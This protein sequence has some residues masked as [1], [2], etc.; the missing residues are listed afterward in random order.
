MSE[1]GWSSFKTD[2]NSSEGRNV[3]APVVPESKTNMRFRDGSDSIGNGLPHTGFDAVEKLDAYAN[4]LLKKCDQLL[5]GF[6]QP[7]DRPRSM[8]SSLASMPANENC[9]NSGS[10]G[11]D[12]AYDEANDEDDND[13]D[14]SVTAVGSTATI[15]MGTSSGVQMAADSFSHFKGYFGSCRQLSQSAT[16]TI[17]WTDEVA[18][19]GSLSSPVSDPMPTA[20]MERSSGARVGPSDKAGKVISRGETVS[21]SFATAHAAGSGGS[22]SENSRVDPTANTSRASAEADEAA[23][24]PEFEREARAQVQVIVDQAVPALHPPL[25]DSVSSDDFVACAMGRRSATRAAASASYLYVSSSSEFDQT[26][27]AA[28]AALDDGVEIQPATAMDS[29]SNSTSSQPQ[30]LRS[31]QRQPAGDSTGTGGGEAAEQ[32]LG[33]DGGSSQTPL[34]QADVAGYLHDEVVRL[35]WTRLSE[36][37]K[38]INR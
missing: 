21:Q 38:E 29:S 2:E 34:A 36:V 5:L 4:N 1:D 27:A 30:Q 25:G 12:D 10:P 13:F 6:A 15:S 19:R 35:L 26:A 11:S 8:S 9:D 16:S 37:R 17:L 32:F 14:Y 7:N 28:A 22:S 20:P 18:D 33:V 24:T 23:V 31:P 3:Q